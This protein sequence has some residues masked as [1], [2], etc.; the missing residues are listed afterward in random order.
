[1]ND[2]NLFL[3]KAIRLDTDN[4]IE[5]NSIK[6]KNSE[7]FIGY[8]H[9]NNIGWLQVKADSIV[10]FVGLYDINKIKIFEK[11]LFKFKFRYDLTSMDY[12]DLVGY[13]TYDDIELRY[14]IDVKH[15]SMYVCLNYMYD[16]MY[17]FEII[18]N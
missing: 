9:S 3:L 12:I 7:T 16:R 17:D 14:Q 2:N 1:M 11:Q 8:E 15:N 6:I 10:R 4:F 18:N 5:G 13:F